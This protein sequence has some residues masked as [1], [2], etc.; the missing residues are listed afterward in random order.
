MKYLKKYKIFESSEFDNIKLV[1]EDI[2]QEMKDEFRPKSKREGERTNYLNLPIDIRYTE[3]GEKNLISIR[4]GTEWANLDDYSINMRK[5]EDTLFRINDYMKS[6]GYSF[7]SFTWDY[8]GQTKFSYTEIGPKAPF[9]S[10]L[11]IGETVYVGF[12]YTKNANN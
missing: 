1:L 2:L 5:S 10:I 9:E 3:R 4:I 6:E 11:K 8:A 7:K 12:F